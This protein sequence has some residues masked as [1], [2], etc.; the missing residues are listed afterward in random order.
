MYVASPDDHIWSVNRFITLTNKT[1][2]AGWIIASSA[3]APQV[4]IRDANYSQGMWLSGKVH[5]LHWWW[6]ELHTQH[7]KKK[8]KN[9]NLADSSCECDFVMKIEYLY[10]QPRKYEVIIRM[11]PNST[12][13]VSLQEKQTHGHKN[14]MK[15]VA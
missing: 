5:T 12:W 7:W 13:L 15:I 2:I 1:D 9:V 8:P 14:N 4:H 10:V 11:D 6:P 3:P